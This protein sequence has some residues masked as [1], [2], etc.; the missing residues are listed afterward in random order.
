M[1]KIG[2]D[3]QKYLET[4]SQHIRDRIA[5]FGDKL[6]LEFGGIFMASGSADVV[7][8]VL[9]ILGI[10]FLIAS[11][12]MIILAM[13]INYQLYKRLTRSFGLKDAWAWGLLFLPYVFLPIIGFHHKRIMYY[14]PVNQV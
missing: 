12:V 4:Q 11:I 10:L 3:N 7:G 8:V 1:M 14:G 13:V 2:F 6:Y 9:L 5:Q